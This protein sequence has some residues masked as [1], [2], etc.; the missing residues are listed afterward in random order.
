[1]S[2]PHE[3]DLSTL[4]DAKPAPA[5]ERRIVAGALERSQPR[6][7]SPWAILVPAAAAFALGAAGVFLLRPAAPV[8]PPGV[9]V[10][11]SGAV[12]EA[13]A[14]PAAFRAGRHLV[15]VEAR[16]R[17]V[18][19]RIEPQAVSLKLSTGAAR[20]EVEH[21]APEEVFRVEA[22]GLTVEAVG[23][24]FVVEVEGECTRVDVAEG[25]VRVRRGGHEP[26]LVSEGDRR[27]Y[28]EPAAGPEVLSEEERML[29][30]AL[31]R[32]RRGKTA[33][34][35]RAA[36]IL[37]SYQERFPKGV[38]QQEALFYLARLS[39][40][41]GRA[42]QAKA[43]AARFLEKFPEGRRADELRPLVAK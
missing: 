17:V 18:A 21:L 23:T 20:F 27:T 13:G 37:Q 40:R 7:R 36:Q 24:Q 8:L 38:Y 33:D 14:A 11:A 30:D 34:L 29:S 3:M 31:E 43:W 16:S 4:R 15:K 41:L 42:D 32:V 12:A 6:A 39:V 5:V 28:C 25:I 22:G 1:M 2:L 35:E 19:S 26:E 10:L 9:P